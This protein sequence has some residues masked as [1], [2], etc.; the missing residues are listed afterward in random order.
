MRKQKIRDNGIIDD[1]I[2][3]TRDLFKKIG[4]IKGA[5]HARM[6]I[7]KDWN[8]KDLSEAKEIKK[9]WREHTEEPY[10]KGLKDLDSHNDVVI[11]LELDILEYEVKWILGSIAVNKAR[12]E[13]DGILAELFK[14]RKEHLLLKGCA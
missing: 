5:F 7:L 13:V 6:G 9:R 8:S 14:I 12:G 4:D 11:H 10:K 3:N 2:E 1:R